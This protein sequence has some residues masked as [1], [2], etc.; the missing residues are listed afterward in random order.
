M[1]KR[2]ANCIEGA[3]FAA[4]ALRFHGHKPL[5]IDLTSVRDDDHIIAVFKEN[6]YWGSIGKSKYTG[7]TFREPIHR[8]IRELAISYFE[9]YFNYEGEKTLRGYS[10][11]INLKVFD[12]LKWMT[13]GDNLFFV[14]K[15]LEKINHKKLITQKM[16][17]NLRIVT[18]LAMEAGELWMS[19]KGILDKVKS[20]S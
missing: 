12:K 17:K 4:A 19:K 18:P 5:I 10:R 9:D 2:K 20:K 7:L 6:G 3:L 11:P 14:E 15:Y 16:V 13:S 1:K 8:T